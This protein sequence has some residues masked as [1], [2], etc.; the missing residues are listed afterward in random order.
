MITK[1]VYVNITFI[2][3]YYCGYILYIYNI[4]H[5]IVLFVQTS[6]RYIILTTYYSIG[7]IYY[8]LHFFIKMESHLHNTINL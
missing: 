7:M 8:M 3:T 1:K 4:A 2:I 5:T 6:T